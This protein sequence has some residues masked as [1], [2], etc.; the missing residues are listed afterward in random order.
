MTIKDFLTK[1]CARPFIVSYKWCRV[2]WNIR[3]C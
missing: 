3:V 1:I 2:L